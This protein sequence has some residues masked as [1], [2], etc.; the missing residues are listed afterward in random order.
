M[1][2]LKQLEASGTMAYLKLTQLGFPT[3][4]SIADFFQNLQPY[5]EQRHISIGVNN[6][7]KI[8]LLASNFLP[9]DFKFGK[10]EIHF[11][12][13]KCDLLDQMKKEFQQPNNSQVGARFKTEFIAS[14]RRILH[15]RIR[16][17]GACKCI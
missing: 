2:V 13:G 17:I 12:P 16:F 15:I 6:C 9:E 8:Y 11:R 10:S 3:K 5:L 4:I 1:F 7:C 14:M